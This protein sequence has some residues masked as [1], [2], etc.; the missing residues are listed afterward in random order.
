M[1]L[2]SLDYN[3]YV[4]LQ[5]I[6]ATVPPETLAVF[7]ELFLYDTVGVATYGASA[8]S[9]STS[10]SGGSALNVV[11]QRRSATP[12]RSAKRPAGDAPVTRRLNRKTT[13]TSPLSVAST[14]P[15]DDA[16]V[17]RRLV[18]KTTHTHQ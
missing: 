8:G 13:Q 16:P 15:A 14:I 7:E 12:P 5:T 4:G 9:A 17:T 10:P 18:R 3:D 11:G 1:I 6:S 2:P